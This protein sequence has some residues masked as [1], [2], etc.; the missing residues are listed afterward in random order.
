MSHDAY[1]LIG[2]SWRHRFSAQRTLA[3]ILGKRWAEAIIPS[4]LLVATFLYFST[5]SP[6][7]LSG[8]NLTTLS[9]VLAE[10]G[11]VS[12]GMT[13]VLVGGGIDLSVG[14]MVAVVN[15][16]AVLAFKLWAWP[17]PVIIFVCALLGC[18]LGSLNGF[19]IAYIKTRPF[20]TTLV[21]LLA[22]RTIANYFDTNYSSK[23]AT[24]I[25]SDSTWSWATN[26]T[27]AGL[28]TAIV[29][30]A[31]IAAIVHLV[32]SRTRWGWRVTAIG[33]SPTSARRAGIDKAMISFTTYVFSGLMSGLAGFL[34]ATRLEQISG[35]T[36]M[37]L[38][39]AVLTAVVLGGVSMSGGRG[40]ASRGVLG[41]TIVA[42]ISQGL[43][44]EGASRHLYS[45][46]L[47]I[48]LLV[49]ATIDLKWGKN[50]GRAIQKIYLVPG[51][52]AIP[53]LPDIYAADSVWKVNDRIT[54]A[55]PIGKGILDGPEDVVVGDDG[56]IYCSDRRGL[57]WKIREPSADPEILARIGGHPLG[58]AI[59]AAGDVI[60]CV[61]GM[62]LYRVTLD[63]EVSAI[64]TEVARS[65]FKINDDS[66]IRLADDL[67]ITE[68]GVIYFSDA[69]T[70][71]DGDEYTLDL[72]EARPNGR[73]LSWDPATDQ[74]TVELRNYPFPNGVCISHD[75][76]SVLI[77]SSTMY[78]IDRYWIAGPKKGTTEPVAEN[79]P[80]IVDNI[81]RASDGT[82]WVAFAGMRSPSWDI[83]LA[84]KKFRRR[85]IRQIPVDEWITPNL[86]MSCVAKMA[87][88]G[89]IL[90]SMWDSS[91]EDHAVITSMR[92]H[93]GYLYL[94][95]LTNNRLGRIRLT[96][97]DKWNDDRIEAY[98]E[99]T[100][101]LVR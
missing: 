89:T 10:L 6:T 94:G 15:S 14:S 69:S 56:T 65:K 75:G 87:E 64:T 29:I 50:R 76:N 12:L 73:L 4:L 2:M 68:D 99:R 20:I 27:V 82:Y 44:L 39:F 42:I 47:A 9:K 23:V 91:Q 46:I 61:A 98:R 77:N 81:N 48:V 101:D 52:M 95:G 38:E 70:R 16:V 32:L 25:R 53:K 28:P 19:L 26:G 18:L 97:D 40:T 13:V 58:V 45:L 78:R 51:L 35:N 80:G 86:N 17:V 59:D 43:I 11:L 54:G 8:S 60:A 31:V 62:G 72:I 41:A 93:D 22:Y 1:G 5:T 67:D 57:I 83:A 74:T 100:K 33:S 85:M 63:G 79:M 66:P 34:I 36:A 7:F 88:D 49:F 37:G 92:E 3:E 24:T 30:L 71:F 96:E 90:Q 84:S 55:E 21:T